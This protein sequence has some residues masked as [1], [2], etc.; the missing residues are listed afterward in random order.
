MNDPLKIALLEEG[1]TGDVADIARSIYQQESGSGKNT[2]TS[3]AGARGGMQ[4]IPATFNRVA[5]KGWAIDDPV[6]NARAGVRYISQLYDKAG[7]DPA[8]TAAGYYGGEGAIAKA[9]KGIAVSDP[10]NPKAPNTLQYGQ[11]VAARLPKKDDDY[12]DISKF[13]GVIDDAPQASNDD[14]SDIE[15]FGGVIDEAPQEATAVDNNKEYSAEELLNARKQGV[16]IGDMKL[17]Q[18]TFKDDLQG[19]I[20]A[21]PLQAAMGAFGAGASNTYEGAKQLLNDEFRQDAPM[22][23]F[24]KAI[25]YNVNG[26]AP[27]DNTASDQQIQ[28]NDMFRENSPV[29]G[30]AGDVAMFAG[31]GVAMPAVNTVKGAAALAGGQGFLQPADSMQERVGAGL[32]SAGVGAGATKGALAIGNKALERIAAKRLAKAQN[33]TTDASL[34]SAQDM[35]LNIPR[36]MYSPSFTSNRIESFGGKAAVKQMALDKNQ[37]I[38]DS[39]VKRAIGVSDDVALSDDLLKSLRTQAAAPYRSAEQL[40][41]ETVGKSSTKSMATGKMIETP[42]IKDGKQ[43]VQ[44]INEARDTTRALWAD[45]KSATGTARNAAREAAKAAESRLATL[46]NQLDKMAINQGKPQLVKE[47][48][49]ARKTIAKLYT[50]DDALNKG[51]GSIDAT[52]LGRKF[53]KN[54]P[55]DGELKEIGRFAK[56]FQAKGIVPKGG[57][58]SGADISALEPMSMAI[59]AGIGSAAT[60]SPAGLLMGGVPLLRSPARKV[61]LSKLMQKAPNYDIGKIDYLSKLL[62]ARNAPSAIAGA[63]IPSFSQ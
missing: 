37:P 6:H 8:L 41:A 25:D 15:K 24:G 18:R 35:G 49:D 52:V 63:A 55:L 11:Q 10:R 44:E 46:E 26:G 30:I 56:T 40:T 60:G 4:I 62:T 61:A 13:G 28:A 19:E 43:L 42:I 48:S 27:I 9:K 54:K 21:N 32:V 36:S 20:D 16:N 12:S 51:T 39:A 31:S 22:G 59:N 1:I 45:S 7:G 53:D 57:V 23:R 2:K 34:K 33:A 29:A 3:N 17:Q 47:L 38:I 50:V 14:Y 5:D 58:L